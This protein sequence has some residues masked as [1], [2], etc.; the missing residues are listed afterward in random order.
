MCI[1]GGRAPT[2]PTTIIRQ[3]SARMGGFARAEWADSPATL[4]RGVPVIIIV[5]SSIQRTPIDPQDLR[6][7]A[8][9]VPRRLEH[10]LDVAP[11]QLFERHE[12]VW[13]AGRGSCRP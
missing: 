12:F 9:V 2:V 7:L 13:A 10:L 3:V 4:R 8:L 1:R 11:L 6:G 5:Q